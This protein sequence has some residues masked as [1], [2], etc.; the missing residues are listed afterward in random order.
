MNLKLLPPLV[1]IALLWGG[2]QS[3]YT[4]LKNSAPEETTCGRVLV[5]PPSA[6]WLSLS[7]C[8]YDLTHLAHAGLLGTVSELYVPLRPRGDGSTAPSRIVLLT[9]DKPLLEV[10]RALEATT[11]AAALATHTERFAATRAPERITGL[12]KFG[13]EVKNDDVEKLRALNPDLPKDFLLLEHGERPM[14]AALSFSLLGAG[15]VLSVW[16][17]WRFRRARVE[18]RAAL[19]APSAQ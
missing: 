19:A 1:A 13:I 8:E 11:D 3:V 15:I 4:S 6:E 9:E 5:Q 2:S 12:V 10:V 17:V 16:L 14:P 7:D 18:E